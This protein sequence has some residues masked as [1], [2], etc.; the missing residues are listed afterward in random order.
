MKKNTVFKLSLNEE[1]AKKLSYLCE[2]ERISVQNELTLLIRQKISYFERVKG[3][4]TREQMASASM[5]QFE[6]EQ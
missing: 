3:S 4:I 1:M 2:K 5:D 6:Q